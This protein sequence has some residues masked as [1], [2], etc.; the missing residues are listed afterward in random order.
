MRAGVAALQEHGAE[1]AGND[2]GYGLGPAEVDG[3]EEVG[4]QGVEHAGLGEGAG[5]L[6]SVASAA[7]D[8]DE[9]GV[10]RS[11]GLAWW[12]GG[13]QGLRGFSYSGELGTGCQDSCHR[14][15]EASLEQFIET[16]LQ[17]LRGGGP[18]EGGG[19]GAARGG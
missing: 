18:G 13:G 15:R 7:L 5:E 8:D 9:L 10:G 1:G 14:F 17:L 16:V 6:V 11:G 19:A 4:D 3:P 2:A 12:Q